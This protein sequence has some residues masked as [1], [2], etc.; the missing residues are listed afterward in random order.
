MKKSKAKTKKSKTAK[1]KAKVTTFLSNTPGEKVEGSIN[2]V[3]SQWVDIDDIGEDP[4]NPN[5]MAGV[6][7]EALGKIMKD[8]G[9]LEDV[10]LN[11]HPIEGKKYTLIN[12][13]QRVKVLKLQ[14]VKRVLAKIIKVT[15]MIARSIGLAMNRNVGKDDPEKLSNLLLYAYKA[16]KLELFLEKIP[17]F[18]IDEAKLLIDKY[19]DTAL[20]QQDEEILPSLPTSTK[21]KLGDLYVLGDHKVLCGDCTDPEH[22][23]KLLG[24]ELVNHVNT[25]PPYGVNYAGKNH[26]LNKINRK[27]NHVPIQ[28]DLGDEDM[29]PFF[30]K[31]LE[32]IPL[33]EYNTLNIWMSGMKLDQLTRA[34]KE[35]GFTWGD[36]LV[37]VKNQFVIGRKDHNPQ[38]EFCLYGWKGKHKFYGGNSASTIYFEKKPLVSGEHPTMKP[39]PLIAKTILEGSKPGDIVYDAFGGSGTTLIACENE[40][41]KARVIE[42]EPHYVD[43]IVKRWEEKTGKK[44]EKI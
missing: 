37:W 7:H 33:T 43:V 20:G 39:V 40:G 24:N 23:K 11:E 2:F 30:S 5:T 17:T 1:K 14:G 41:R 31:F 18:G 19:H 8:H 42:L 13:H 32:V 28:G 10:V 9:W 34:F 16:D 12:G 26:F 21:T 38:H 44:A 22:V 25:D 36:Y 4:M 35:S 3:I 15:P 29:T 27:G 6:Q